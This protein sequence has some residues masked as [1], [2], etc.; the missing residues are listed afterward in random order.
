MKTGDERLDELT[1]A[2]ASA[3]QAVKAANTPALREVAEQALTAARKAK[4]DYWAA[5]QAKARAAYMK[6]LLG[7]GV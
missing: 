7:A 3:E 1:D 4:A 2:V 5:Y 6:R